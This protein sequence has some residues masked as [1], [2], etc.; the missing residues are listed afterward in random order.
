MIGKRVQFHEETLAAIE[1][2]AS[3]RGRD[4][5][6]IAEEAFAEAKFGR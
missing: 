3:Q 4:F 5:R 6:D 2:V 1:V